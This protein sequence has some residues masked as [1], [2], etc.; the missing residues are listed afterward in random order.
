MPCI[1]PCHSTVQIKYRYR[2]IINVGCH[3]H[4]LP[5][6][7]LPGAASQPIH[8]AK[9]CEHMDEL[10]INQTRRDLLIAGALS[11]TAAAV[12]SVAAAQATGTTRNET[13]RPPVT[14]KVAL[15]VN[16]KRLVARGTQRR[17]RRGG[18]QL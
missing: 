11:A 18:H 8:P 15:T 2:F 7:A 14:S 1:S 6:L 16:G 5:P 17:R 12:P 10:D 13:P 9:G 4:G 3:T